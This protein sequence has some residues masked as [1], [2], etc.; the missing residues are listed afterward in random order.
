MLHS[1]TVCN[2]L[3]P[4]GQEPLQYQSGSRLAELCKTAMQ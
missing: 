2:T 4:V 3:S 1:N